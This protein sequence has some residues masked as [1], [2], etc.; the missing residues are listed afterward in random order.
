M[1]NSSMTNKGKNVKFYLCSTKHHAMKTYW[2][3]EVIFPRIINLGTRWR[4]VV[5]F[6]TRPLY[7]RSKSPRYALDRRL[8]GRRE[9]IPSI[10]LPGI[11]PRSSSL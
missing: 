10:L 6:T 5:S 2:E 8:G 7:S 3:V 11:E 4:W 9:N 1:K